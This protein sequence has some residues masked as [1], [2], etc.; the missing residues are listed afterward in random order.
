MISLTV[1]DSNNNNTTR[2]KNALIIF[3][4]LPNGEV[5]MIGTHTPAQDV[6]L[7]GDHGA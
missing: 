6:A 5:P 4:S 1:T 7:A 2:N 3:V